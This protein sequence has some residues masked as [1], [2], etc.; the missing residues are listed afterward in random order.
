MQ[1]YSGQFLLNNLN[2]IIHFDTSFVYTLRYFLCQ[3]RRAQCDNRKIS[4]KNSNEKH[5]FLRDD[6]TNLQCQSEHILTKEENM[7]GSKKDTLRQAQCDKTVV[8]CIRIYL[9]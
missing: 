6:N 9:D 4:S 1:Y 2:T 7:E 8:S 5:S 3:Y